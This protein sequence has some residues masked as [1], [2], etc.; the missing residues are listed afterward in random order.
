[1]LVGAVPLGSTFY[2]WMFTQG[3]LGTGAL[4][5]PDPQWPR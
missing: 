4:V 2:V 5:A 3:V 1:M